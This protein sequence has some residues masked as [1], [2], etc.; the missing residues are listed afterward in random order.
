[1]GATPGGEFLAAIQAA[2]AQGAEVSKCCARCS[3]PLQ[4]VSA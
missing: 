1:M 2:R 3:G 4:C